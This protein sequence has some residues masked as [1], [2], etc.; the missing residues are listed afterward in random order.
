MPKKIY[1]EG[2]NR[3]RSVGWTELASKLLPTV[4]EI[5]KY[6]TARNPHGRADRVRMSSFPLLTP[7]L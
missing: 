7:L 6:E 1:K 4:V 3:G 2:N 5:T